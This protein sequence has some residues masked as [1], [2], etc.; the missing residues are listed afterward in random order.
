MASIAASH[1]SQLPSVLAQVAVHLKHK[2]W[3][4]RVAA[5]HCLGLLAEHF[6][7][8]SV[9][10]LS[11]AAGVSAEEL[12]AAAAVKQ[13]GGDEEGAARHL[14]HFAG[15]DIT[16]VLGQGTALLASWGMVRQ[17]AC[18]LG[19]WLRWSVLLCTWKQALPCL[20]TVS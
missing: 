14:L 15:F 5:A 9:P 4:A 20:A 1:P 12:A 16:Q 8:T 17:L 2:E 18:T 10:E 6:V 3:D 13:E 19:T 7:H 11:Q